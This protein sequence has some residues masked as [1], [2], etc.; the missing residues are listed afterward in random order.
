MAQPTKP[1]EESEVEIKKVVSIREDFIKEE[2]IGL[3]ANLARWGRKRVGLAKAVRLAELD[4]EIEEKRI[5]KSARARRLEEIEAA[6]KDTKLK[7]LTD[8]AAEELVI[9]DPAYRAARVRVIEAQERRDE[10]GVVVDA[11]HAK[12]EMIVSLGATLRLEIESDP[13]IR[14]RQQRR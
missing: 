8:D 4:L 1:V 14:D 3:S 13:S 10:T 9:T 11:I 7:P 5:K 6:G 2:Y 12:R